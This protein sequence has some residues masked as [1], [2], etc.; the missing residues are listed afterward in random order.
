MQI[1]Q[2]Q[3]G[4]RYRKKQGFS[5]VEVLMGLFVMS[6]IF[7]FVYSSVNFTSLVG[8]DMQEQAKVANVLET[9]AE[10]IMAMRTSSFSSIVTGISYTSTDIPLMTEFISP[11]MSI[12]VSSYGGDASLKLVS[13][14]FSWQPVSKKGVK[15]QTLK[16]LISEPPS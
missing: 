16:T 4:M 6:L 1:I 3:D 12:Q 8:A 7:I 13:I 10:K 2:Y 5:L 15:S 9:A 14:T 11:S